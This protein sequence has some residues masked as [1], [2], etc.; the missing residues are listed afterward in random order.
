MEVQ[1][2]DVSIYD[3]GRWN[4]DCTFSGNRRGWKIEG[5]GAF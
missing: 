2:Y 1:D 3:T 5:G 4:R